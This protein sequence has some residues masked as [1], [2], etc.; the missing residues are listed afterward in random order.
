MMRWCMFFIASTVEAV[1][2]IFFYESF[3]EHRWGGIKRGASYCALNITCMLNAMVV[4][5]LS[6]GFYPIKLVTL[7]LI[8]I[9]FVRICYRSKWITSGFF[10][11]E[12]VLL[13]LLFETIVGGLLQVNDADRF[14]LI[15]IGS[16]V[17]N[18]AYFAIMFL[19]RKRLSIIKRFVQGSPDK[20]LRFI[21][22][23]F[24]STL[25]GLYFFLVFMQSTLGYYEIL[26]SAMILIVNIA[27]LFIMQELM[28]KDER[29]RLSEVQIES[30]QNQLQAFRDM[31]S[32]Y[33][34]Q[35]KKLHDYKKQL[36]TVQE[37]LRNGDT[38][39][40]IDYIGQLTKSISV[41]VS[42]VNVGHPVINAVLNQQYRVAKGKNI[43]MTFAVS[44]LHDIRLSD[45]DI[46]IL[47]GNLLENAIHECERVV[48]A[49]RTASVQIKF[50]EK[51]ANILLT[52]R[53]PVVEKI[54]I[55]ENRVQKNHGEGHGIGL[56]NVESV[57]EKYDGSFAISCDEEEFTAV[58]MI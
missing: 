55:E 6:N 56:V 35:G 38:E 28:V 23:P 43:G 33:E 58:V 22:L 19:L 12:S 41:E 13:Q 54:S 40:A 53:N 44:D 24:I 46:V 17:A 14:F 5:A 52:V 27:A 21:W 51:G 57:V 26:V 49:G 37:L 10:A 7:I 42:E 48:N 8:H 20:L 2:W 9:L 36:A 32:L 31:Q 11:T 29:I 25:V 39:T 30:K 45:D 18:L 3:L 47:L 4:E 15:W 16:I 34:R 50:V 1:V